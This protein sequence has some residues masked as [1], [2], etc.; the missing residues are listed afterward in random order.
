MPSLRSV[1]FAAAA[2]L[3]ATVQ[4]DYY[5]DPKSVAQNDR[6]QWCT[7]QIST[8]PIICQQNPPGTTLVNTCDWETL[9]YGCVCGNGIKPNV[10][11]YSLTLPYFV[12]SEW[13]NQCVKGCGSNSQCANDCREKHPC[14]AQNPTRVNITSTTSSGPNPTAPAQTGGAF[15][16]LAGGAGGNGKN[17]GTVLRAG[18]SMGLVVLLGG[19]VAGLALLV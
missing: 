15:D 2:T 16:G 19:A 4:A 3:V 11:E 8:C 14:G 9:T 1:L 12:C 5:V 7:A 13:G 6:R 17:F 18:E 10:S